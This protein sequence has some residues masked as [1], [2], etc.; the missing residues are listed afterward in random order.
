MEQELE[1][2]DL[3]KEYVQDDNLIEYHIVHL[4][5]N[6]IIGHTD[7]PSSI[8]NHMQFNATYYNIHTKKYRKGNYNHDEIRGQAFEDI[9]NISQIFVWHDSSFA[10]KFSKPQLVSEMFQTLYV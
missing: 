1:Y 5:P 2:R 3:S 10:I 6:G 4:Y 7:G 9:K 8:H